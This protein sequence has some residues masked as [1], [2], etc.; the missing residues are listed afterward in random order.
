MENGCE[1]GERVRPAGRRPGGPL[2]VVDIYDILFSSYGPQGW[3]PL[4]SRAGTPGYD[5]E[6]YHP[7][8]YDVPHESGAFE[9]AVGA[10]LVQNI[11][12]MSAR[13]ALEAL[14]EEGRCSPGGI[15]GLTEEALAGLI[16]PCGYYALKARRLMHLARFFLNL[17][18]TPTREDLLGVW[19]VGRETADSILLYGYG[20]PVCVVDAYTRRIFHRLGL[21]ARTDVPY[22]EVRR[23][24]EDGL[25]ADH[26]VYNEFHA[27]LVEHAKRHC[28]K[29]PVCDGCPLG[30]RCHFFREASP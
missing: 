14:L 30:R 2:T 4:L 29:Q 13:R 22:E 27:L 16:R 26:V 12:W 8:M 23:A 17:R 15:L 5:E 6:G 3:W 21:L 25:R 9:I 28:K 19:G 24:V 10:V 18:G 1:C 11:A 20:V 7:G